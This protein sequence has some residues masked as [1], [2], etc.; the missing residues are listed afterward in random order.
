[1]TEISDVTSAEI[2]DFDDI[3][4]GIIANSI[5]SKTEEEALNMLLIQHLNTISKQMQNE[6]SLKREIALI[7]DSNTSAISDKILEFLPA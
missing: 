7:E 3:L 5:S 2:I 4:N 6:E 1:M